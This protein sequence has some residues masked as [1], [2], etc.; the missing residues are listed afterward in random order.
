M[1]V[2]KPQRIGLQLKQTQEL[3]STT[4]PVPAPS[5]DL[6]IAFN[7]LYLKAEALQDSQLLTSQPF[8][9]LFLFTF[10]ERRRQAR[11]ILFKGQPFNE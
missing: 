1:P 9:P 10:S 5:R 3:R 11:G 2:S 6:C 4:N 8:L 7:Q